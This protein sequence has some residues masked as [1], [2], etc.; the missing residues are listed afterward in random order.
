LLETIQFH[1]EDT[2]DT[3]EE[4]QHRFP[5]GMR[6]GILTITEITKKGCEERW[7]RAASHPPHVAEAAD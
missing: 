7:E 3:P 6:L 5:I 1:R 4:F 2:E